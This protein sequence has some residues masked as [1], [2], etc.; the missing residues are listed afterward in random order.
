MSKIKICGIKRMED[1]DCVNQYLPDYIG[2][3][4]YKKSSRYITS[5]TAAELKKNLNPMIKAVGVFVNEDIDFISNLCRNKIIDMIQ[6]HGNE[7]ENYI[8]NLKS[9]TDKKIIKAIRVQNQSQILDAASLPAD[10]VLLDTYIKEMYGGSGKTFDHSLIPSGYRDFF[11]AGGLDCL[12][13]ADI[14]KKC[15]PYCVDLSSS[16]ETGGYKDPDKIR[17]IINIV[18]AI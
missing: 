8:N 3:V 16:V 15:N 1:I 6:L 5:S 7:D 17:Q 18:R 4:F 13:I 12:N 2:F 11:L 9:I 14:I 10:Y